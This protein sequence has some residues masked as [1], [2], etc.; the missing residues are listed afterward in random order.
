MPVTF[1]VLEHCCSEV[2]IGEEILTEQN[3]FV[4]NSASIV[5]TATLDDDD[6]Y[7][8]APFDFI[9]SW[10][11]SC[12]R[13]IAKATFMRAKGSLV[14]PELKLKCLIHGC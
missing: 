14:D 9:N 2:I 3:V 5:S 10:Q 12:R 4:E 1:E 13:A 8:L 11:R 7:R 6:S